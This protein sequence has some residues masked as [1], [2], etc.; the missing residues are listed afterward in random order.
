ME[1]HTDWVITKGHPLSKGLFPTSHYLLD[2]CP[3]RWELIAGDALS[4]VII[5]T[6]RSALS[7]C[8]RIKYLQLNTKLTCI[9]KQNK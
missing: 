2:G 9:S 6:D 7:V 8:I 4:L 1:R 5:V 3:I